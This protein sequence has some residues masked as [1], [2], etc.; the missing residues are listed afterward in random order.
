MTKLKITKNGIHYIENVKFMDLIKITGNGFPIC[1][2]CLKDLI[3]FNNLILI[4]I[5]NEVYCKECGKKELK[6]INYYAEDR[7]VEEKRTAYYCDV[8]NIKEN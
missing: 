3:G 1:D 8:L 6:T 4:P 7:E 2:K 5:R